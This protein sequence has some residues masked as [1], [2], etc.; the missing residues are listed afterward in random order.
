MQWL[1]NLF[2][3]AKYCILDLAVLVLFCIG[4]VRIVQHEAMRLHGAHKKSQGR[5]PTAAPQPKSAAPPPINVS[6]KKP[7]KKKSTTLPRQQEPTL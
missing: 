7:N 2:D 6:D 3:Q 1:H 4:I 5:G